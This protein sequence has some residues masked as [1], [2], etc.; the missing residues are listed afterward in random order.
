MKICE[1]H[2]TLISTLK[3]FVTKHEKTGL[4]VCDIKVQENNNFNY[5]Y[6]TILNSTLQL[7]LY[8]CVQR[9]AHSQKCWWSLYD[10]NF[11]FKG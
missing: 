6:I 9:F 11:L 8:C 5:N 4:H 3:L 7:Q 1:N 2:K 10:R